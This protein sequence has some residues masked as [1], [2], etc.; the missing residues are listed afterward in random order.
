MARRLR[1]FWSPGVATLTVVAL[2]VPLAM[3]GRIRGGGRIDLVGRVAV[4]VL[5]DL[6]HVGA[7][8]GAA[9]GR[10]GLGRTAHH[11]AVVRL[12]GLVGVRVLGV[13]DGLL[14]ARVLVTG[15]PRV[16]R[17]AA[18]VLFDACWS[19]PVCCSSASVASTFSSACC[20]SSWSRSSWATS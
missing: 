14:G 2:A 6:A 10:L 20:S 18:A 11:G 1:R 4:V 7:A 19:S 3:A 13:G 8:I 16:R 5:G 15:G 9:V 17:D 12:V